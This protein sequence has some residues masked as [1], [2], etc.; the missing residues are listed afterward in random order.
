MTNLN[1]D[2]EV[3][4]IWKPAYHNLTTDEKF[5]SLNLIKIIE[6][7]GKNHYK[8][9]I[10]A[11]NLKKGICYLHGVC[12]CSKTAI[13]LW[14]KTI[15]KNKRDRLFIHKQSHRIFSAIKYLVA[16]DK[17]LEKMIVSLNEPIIYVA[18]SQKNYFWIER[19]SHPN[20]NYDDWNN[21]FDLKQQLDNIQL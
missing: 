6:Y 4:A 14:C 8:E 16:E 17:E 13:K 19:F 18:L 12:S 21:L 2:L 7:I 10:K 15:V 5:T 9:K 3:R 1:K 20:S 11:S